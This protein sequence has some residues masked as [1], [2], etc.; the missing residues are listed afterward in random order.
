M[1]DTTRA[2]YGPNRSAPHAIEA[3]EAVLGCVL[4]NPE[5]YFEVAPILHPDD[6]YIHKH[7]W[8]WEAFVG[9]HDQRL[10][11]DIITVAEELERHNQLGE[12][13]GSPG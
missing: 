9:L 12:V 2:D 8:I 4:I 1:T 10:P 5:A 6:F 13:G 11:I 7:R 3:E